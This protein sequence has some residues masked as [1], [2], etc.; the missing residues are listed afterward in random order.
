MTF[1]YFCDLYEILARI[2]SSLVFKGNVGLN[3]DISWI[4]WWVHESE[5]LAYSPGR[6]ILFLVGDPDQWLKSAVQ[7]NI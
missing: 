1:I 4:I 3:S 6:K 5:T 7:N 2:W